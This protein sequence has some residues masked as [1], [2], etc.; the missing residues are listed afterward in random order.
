MAKYKVIG[1]KRTI[2]TAE[3]T[4]DTFDPIE[5]VSQAGMAQG[6]SFKWDPGA[7]ITELQVADDVAK[8]LVEAGELEV[9]EAPES[10]SQ[11]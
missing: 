7:E 3:G 6:K 9:I 2:E 10:W 1:K 4:R 8:A 11:E 5:T